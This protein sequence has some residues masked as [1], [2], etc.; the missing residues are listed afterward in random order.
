M[1]IMKRQIKMQIFLL[2]LPLVSFNVMAI[3]QDRLDNYLVEAAENNPGLKATFNEYM[4]ALQKVPQVGALPDPQI[5]FGYFIQPVETKV[6]P[7]KARISASQMFPWFGTLGARKDVATEMARSKYEQFREARSRLFYD[8]KSTYYNLYFIQRAIGIATENI[9]IL[10]TFRKLSL[11]K[12]ESGKA[13]SADVLRVEMKIA[14]LENE[15]ALLRD[16]FFATQAGFNLLLNVEAHRIVNVPDSLTDIGL[17]MSREAV[18]DS[19]RER[20]P[21]VL[22]L[23]FA[24]ASYQKQEIVAGNSGKPSFSIGF[25]YL[26]VEKDR[27]SMASVSNPGKDA[28][29]FPT[30]GITIPLYRKKYTAMVKEAALMQKSVHNKKLNKINI[31]ESTYEKADKDYRDSDRRIGLYLAQSDKAERT[32]DILETLYETEGKDFEDVLTMEQQFLKYKLELEKAR[33]DKGAA[34]AFIHYLAGK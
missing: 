29:I 3:A 20:N 9:D 23:N 10:H 2:I 12:V 14:D 7:Q 5:S 34:I 11:T 6:G 22:R 21:E 24:E 31:L 19:I 18:L 16:N 15:L 17:E 25:D 32:L 1:K 33:S 8:V 4:A 28:F 26:V 27:N 13:S 30:I